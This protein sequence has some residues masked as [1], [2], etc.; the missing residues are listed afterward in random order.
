MSEKNKLRAVSS[1][2]AQQAGGGGGNGSDRELHGRVS[3]IEAHLQHLATK[4]D[5][6]GIKT[7]I[8][9]R[10]ARTLRWLTRIIVVAAASIIVSLISLVVV[11]ME[12]PIKG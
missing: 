5:I 2:P 1:P 4:E 11:L 6:Q 3:A 8:A 9:E 10:E 12:F 7:L